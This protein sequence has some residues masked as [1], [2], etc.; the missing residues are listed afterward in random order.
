MHGNAGDDFIQGNFSSGNGDTLYGDAGQDD[1][2]GGTAR[3]VTTDPNSATNGRCDGK[4]T[5]Y[6]GDSVS[7][8]ASDFDVIMGDNAEIERLV[9]AGTGQWKV[10]T[11]NAAIT[12]KVTLFDVAVANGPVVDPGT[13]GADVLN[14][15]ANDD[16]MYG[17]GGNDDMSGGNGDD[18][19][20]GNAGNDDMDG[21]GGNDDM[22][23]GTGQINTDTVQGTDGR[24]DGG[25]GDGGGTGMRGG[26]GFDF[27]VGDN[28]VVRR[29]LSNVGAWIP[30][31]WNGG[32]EHEIVWLRDLATTTFSPAGGTSGND[33][34]LGDSEDDIMYGQG[35]NDQ[36]DGGTQQDYMEGNAGTDTMQGNVGQD[37]ITGGT[38]R[39][40]N[41]P[42]TGTPG[43][44]DTNDNLYGELGTEEGT[45]AGSGV[46]AMA[47]DNAIITHPLTQ[48]GQ[49]QTNSFNGAFTRN[50]WLLDVATLS[51]PPGNNTS[52]GDDMYG[53]SNDDVMY[54]Q[55]GND[56]MHGN[57][58]Q[59]YMEGNSGADTMFGGGNQDDMAGGTGRI[60]N[61]PATGTAGRLDAGDKMY[62]D[63]NTDANTLPTDGHD[64]MAGD[65]AII[66][67]PLTAGGA[68]I[69]IVYTHTIGGVQSSTSRITRDVYTPVDPNPSPYVDTNV[70]G[71][72]LM[73]GNGGD[74]DMYGQYDDAAASAL[75]HSA[76]CYYAAGTNKIEG[77]LM[78][79]DAGEDA[80]LGDNGK[81]TN[82]A[83]DGSRTRH[84]EIQAPFIEEDI[85]PVGQLSRIVELVR[86][87]TNASGSDTA[88]GNDV[89]QGGADGDWMHG[90]AGYDLING[91]GG[92]DVA[93]GDDG[94]DA[95][96]GGT[97][98]DHTYGGYGPGGTVA[99]GPTGNVTLRGDYLDIEPRFD[100]PTTWT[101]V[102]P[103]ADSL[104]DIDIVY[105]GW[106]RDAMQADIG[107]P[108][109]QVGD[110]LVDWTGAYNIYFT[111]P[112][113]YGEGVATR[114]L[115]PDMLTY[116]LDQSLGDGALDPATRN[117]SG[118]DELGLVYTRD[119]NQNSGPAYPD[120]PGHFVCPTP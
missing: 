110:R 34:M 18:Y 99:P 36:M 96:W 49:W 51:T 30:Q 16:L 60:N 63:S 113:A 35:G 55:G 28:A 1:L 70:S 64:A 66:S 14:G 101:L 115:S 69:P 17:Q 116:L 27:M 13:S 47:G 118:F 65:N 25:E 7:D 42:A 81:V 38:G 112:G 73:R 29:K 20:E 111:C 11:F 102:A 87:Q 26:P 109:P 90:G 78:C 21:D 37:D 104:Q 31:T 94:D 12:R 3:T 79:G 24:F 58:G 54:G 71:S 97:G 19:M 61:D 53:N 4:D 76:P 98:N 108:G 86:S 62:G 39:I 107:G 23:G 83:E 8:L 6:G 41:D 89:M 9:D 85:F 72:D 120:T 67:R 105:G 43:R 50:F 117:S 100:D 75:T 59:D 106:G 91:N 52:G 40:N 48:Q 84:I 114:Q 77:D 88:G 5:V 92:N 93:F 15:E 56:T 82:R 10:N 103:I 119:V 32:F 45:D 44:L 80:M 33:L 95:V 2:I 46:D 68:W 57:A 22:V 74:D